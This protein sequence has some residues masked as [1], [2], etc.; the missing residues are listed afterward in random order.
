M[1]KGPRD[2]QIDLNKATA[3]ELEAIEG[4]DG[5]RA[6]LIIE[7]RNERGTFQSWEDVLSVP[8][9]DSVLL[10]KLQKGSALG[11]AAGSPAAGAG[12]AATGGAKTTSGAART[13]RAAGEGDI[14]DMAALEQII[15]LILLDMAAAQAYR[16]AIDACKTPEIR[17]QLEAFRGDHE[18][19]AREL[20]DA[21]GA[22]LPEQP[23]ERGQCIQRYTELSAREDRTALVAMC[24]NEE[25]TNDAYAS[26][27]AS[28]LPDDV[29][30][31]VE[32]NW[33]D[34]RRHIRWIN[35]EIRT[36]GW[37]LPEVPSTL[38]DAA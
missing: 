11:D 36:R 37:E 2:A 38:A 14:G 9:I 20:S 12:A 13:P 31:M 28:D 1:A 22:S 10:G 27:L 32:A 35:E 15:G 4:I 18:R 16:V 21:L 7:H 26:A 25:L 5:E 23:D 34:E 24:G 8:G 30:R 33:Q 17:R 19:H 3:E 29:R 6:R